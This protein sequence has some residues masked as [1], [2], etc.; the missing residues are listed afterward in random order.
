MDCSLLFGGNPAASGVVACDTPKA[1]LSLLP[2]TRS[3]TLLR[4]C[5]KDAAQGR[6][7]A[8]GCVATSFQGDAEDGSEVD[9]AD[10]LPGSD[11]EGSFSSER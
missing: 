2:S 7:A 4:G 5:G 3:A 8:T 6:T 1:L 11:W 9:E 10:N